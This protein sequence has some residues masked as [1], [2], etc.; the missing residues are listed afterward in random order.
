VE[1]RAVINFLVLKMQ[2]LTVATLPTASAVPVSVFSIQN[3]LFEIS[4]SV[5]EPDG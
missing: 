1:L 2:V 4:N 3:S 5:D